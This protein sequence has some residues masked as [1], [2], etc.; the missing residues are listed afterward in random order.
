LTHEPPE[1]WP[2]LQTTGKIEVYTVAPDHARADAISAFREDW[3]CYANEFEPSRT[4]LAAMRAIAAVEGSGYA[5]A[6]LGRDAR[7]LRERQR[8]R[9]RATCATPHTTK[10]AIVIDAAQRSRS[11]ARGRCGVR[12]GGCCSWLVLVLTTCQSRCRYK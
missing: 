12:R 9:R 10:Y 4:D 7:H 3:L 8:S 2:D 1:F 5:P 6:G 11:C